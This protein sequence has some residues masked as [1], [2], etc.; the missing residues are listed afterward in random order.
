L[1]YVPVGL[2]AWL[3]A[4]EGLVLLLAL[5]LVDLATAR[6]NGLWTLLTIGAAFGISLIPMLITNTLVSGDPLTVPRM[7]PPYATQ[8]D[9]VRFVG[10]AVWAGEGGTTGGSG[11]VSDPNSAG[12]GGTTGKSGEVSD[13]NSAGESGSGLLSFFSPLIVFLSGLAHPILRTIERGLIFFSFLRQG[14]D[15][16]VTHPSKI[17]HTFIRS[18]YVGTQGTGASGLA[19]NLTFFEAL[20]IAGALVSIPIVVVNELRNKITIKALSQRLQSAGGTADA[21]V[22]V[23]SITLVLLYIPRFPLHAMLTVRYIYPLFPLAIYGLVRLQTVQ[24]V[25]REQST[26]LGFTYGGGVLIGGQVALLIIHVMEYGVDE[27]MQGFALLALGFM[28][29]VAIWSTLGLFSS[30]FDRLGGVIFGSAAAVTTDLMVLIAYYYFGNGFVL[31]LS[32]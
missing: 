26:I 31:P 21:F 28:I 23:Y 15:A 27:A 22:L 19:I 18:G 29:G 5:L 25:L 13:P 20:P 4:A 24:R 6:E 14:I 9:E 7:L 11:E 8:G 10:D 32:P 17:Y 16:I 2:T 30:D 3:N 1:A 12:E